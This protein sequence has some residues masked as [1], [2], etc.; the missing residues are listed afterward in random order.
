[1]S[2]PNQGT[3][4]SDAP[5]ELS[6]DASQVDVLNAMRRDRL[7]AQL[8]EDTARERRFGRFL[9]RGELGHGGMG[10][11]LDAVDTT[12]HRPVAL[13][14]LHP[15][16]AARQ[17]AR[18]L[19]EAQLL[20]KISHPNVVVVYEAG[21]AD[22]RLFIAMELVRG[23]TLR[24]WQRMR[25][26]WRACLEAYRQAGRGL[27]AAH[28]HGIVHRDFKPSN[29]M[30]DEDGR[31]RVL[32]FGLAEGEHEGVGNT[33]GTLAYMAPEQLAGQALDARSDQFSF[34]VALFE[35]VYGEHPF[36]RET[37]AGTRAAIQEGEVPRPP[38]RGVP[39]W[40]DQALRRG[41]ARDPAA[42]WPDMERLLH[43]LRPRNWGR[44]VARLALPLA[45]V[46]VAAWW[47]TPADAPVL[48]TGAAANAA[49][50]WNEARRE[51]AS[52]GL[53]ATGLALAEVSWPPVE[54]AV[55]A[56]V[57]QWIDAQTE[58]CRA[59]QVLGEQSAA[60]MDQRM[61][62]LDQRLQALSSTLDTFERAD[63]DTVIHAV[64]AAL[65]LPEIEPCT[66]L[67]LQPESEP[68]EALPLRSRLIAALA[69]RAAGHFESAHRELEAIRAEAEQQG[70]SALAAEVLWR[71]GRVENDLGLGEAADATFE[72]AMWQALRAG[73]DAMAFEA[74]IARDEVMGVLLVDPKRALPGLE[75]AE[76]LLHRSGDPEEGR[77]EYLIVAGKVLG[78]HGRYERAAAELAEAEALVQRLHGTHHVRYADVLNELGALAERTNQLEAAKHQFERVLELDRELYGPNH[79]AVASTLNNLAIVLSRMGHFEQAREHLTRSLELHRAALGDHPSVADALMNL[80][81]TSFGQQRFADAERETHEAHRIYAAQLG[82]QASKTLDA[83]LAHGMS[84]EALGRPE[85]AEQ[86]FR[87]VLERKRKALGERHPDIQHPLNALGT[88]LMSTGRAAEAVEPLQLSYELTREAV[89][90]A[91]LDPATSDKL[92]QRKQQLEQAQGLAQK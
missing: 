77:I 54:Q 22:E 82:E 70:L 31:V 40:V 35:A 68:P 64:D 59:T 37:A 27:E 15:N 18:L 84:L 61:A 33:A 79:L 76:A 41:L 57:Q 23:Q 25:P 62:C 34:C 44:R 88:L 60:L 28:A 75:H 11:V 85:Q 67:E 26:G 92:A 2:E 14:L 6:I 24:E 73:D 20:A 46:A 81:G 17:G 3:G 86:A 16:L 90:A 9:V 43:A 30:I 83:E 51:R 13:K 74:A 32:D 65:R 12:L 10:T 39:R 63:A 69:E 38:R 5:S 89:E 7:R 91:G 45:G 1:M 80:G 56:Y 53:T 4:P 52:A 66:T 78:R 47:V 49:E 87:S 55:D 72:A 21:Q 48:C 19:R 36:V 58:V 29:C 50:V 71:R 8:F 42:R